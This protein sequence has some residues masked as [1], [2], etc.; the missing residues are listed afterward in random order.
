MTVTPAIRNLIREDKVHQI[1]TFLQS[2]SD[3]G[4]ISF[5]RHLAERY[6]DGLISKATALELAHDTGEFKRLAG[7]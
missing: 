7:L 3:L 2:C 5:D 6:I 1:G 4:M